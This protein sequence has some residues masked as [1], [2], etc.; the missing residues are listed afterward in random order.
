MWQG[1]KTIRHLAVLA[2]A[3]LALAVPTQGSALDCRP[4]DTNN[5]GVLDEHDGSCIPVGGSI[6]QLRPI[7]LALPLL[8]KAG[9]SF[10][11]SQPAPG[12]SKSNYPTA[13]PAP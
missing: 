13:S 5:D 6:G 12:L 7:N 4:F 8:E 11:A 3:V 10:A 2:V 1:I 9:L